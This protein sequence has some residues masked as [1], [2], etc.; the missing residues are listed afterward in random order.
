MDFCK[1]AEEL[2]GRSH[3]IYVNGLATV[4]AFAEQMGCRKEAQQ[5]LQEAEDLHQDCLE[6]R[7][8]SSKTG[9]KFFVPRT[10]EE[11]EEDH[12]RQCNVC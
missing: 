4:A 5:L 1:S 3:P 7:C 11:Y 9:V 6:D 2:M 10:Q 8:D 12:S